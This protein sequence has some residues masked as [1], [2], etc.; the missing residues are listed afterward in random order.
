MRNILKFLVLP[1]FGQRLVFFWVTV[2]KAGSCLFLQD[3]SL[4]SYFSIC[5]MLAC[6]Y[7]AGPNASSPNIFHLT[8]CSTAQLENYAHHTGLGLAH[9]YMKW[10]LVAA[11]LS[12]FYTDGICTQKEKNC[13]DHELSVLLNLSWSIEGYHWVDKERRSERLN[14]PLSFSSCLLTICHVL[15]GVYNECVPC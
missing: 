9:V 15:I 14:D 8:E 13:L 5:K 4:K 12:Y 10:Q 6:N 11:L 3:T 7:K 1:S 2:L